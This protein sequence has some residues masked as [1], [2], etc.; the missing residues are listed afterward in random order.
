MPVSSIYDIFWVV[1]KSSEYWDDFSEG[2]LAQVILLTVYFML[3]YKFIL[4]L[5]MWK[6]S[7][8]FQKFVN[9]QRELVGMR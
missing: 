7:L 5:V 8:N 3:F 4:F 2:G 9:Q 6:A 1:E